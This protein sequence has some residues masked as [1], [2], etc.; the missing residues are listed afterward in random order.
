MKLNLHLIF[1]GFLCTLI[2]ASISGVGAVD[3]EIP[4]EDLIQRIESGDASVRRT[5]V[6]QIARRGPEA[7]KAVPALIQVL[8]NA[9]DS[10]VNQVGYT[11]QTIG[12]SAVPGITELL[13][14]GNQKARLNAIGVLG[15]FGAAG[16][17]ATP[18]LISAMDDQNQEIRFAAVGVIAAIGPGAKAAI[19][20]LIRGLDDPEP[21]I[22]TRS[23]IALGEIQVASKEVQEALLRVLSS[24]E[25]PRWAHAVRPIGKL[26]IT[27]ALPRMLELLKVDQFNGRM[28]LIEAFR[29][30]GSA[31]QVCIPALIEV[32]NEQMRKSE[33]VPAD[34]SLR[35]LLVGGIGHFAPPTK[36]QVNFFAGRLSGPDARPAA[37][38]LAR[39][40][41]EAA[42]ALPALLK[43]I[44][45]GNEGFQ[46][47]VRRCLL[48]IGTPAA[49]E[50]VR[51][52]K[53]RSPLDSSPPFDR[54]IF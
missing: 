22:V 5:A 46:W 41:K 8:R 15:R 4:I 26:K 16:A 7:Q 9:D 19:P 38:V 28:F 24:N 54:R 45:T 33:S 52:M 31:G 42:P 21:T 36:A 12:A 40:G 35:I 47:Y 37:E 44:N 10:L 51:Q 49:M 53:L 17:I 14:D 3:G 43:V 6:A 1:P 25:W 29:E 48:N 27:S 32:Y 2:L 11:L 13:K 23:A 30:M 20:R 34:R 50:G 18:L 39:F